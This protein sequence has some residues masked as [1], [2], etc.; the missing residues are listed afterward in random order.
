[1]LYATNQANDQPE[2]FSVP[3]EF[4][5]TSKSSFCRPIYPPAG[6]EQVK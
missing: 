5:F 6:I 4:S 1:M 3:H 2:K